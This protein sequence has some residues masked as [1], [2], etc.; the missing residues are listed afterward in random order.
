MVARTSP[1][2]TASPT[3]TFTLATVPSCGA[4]TGISIFMASSTRTVSPAFTAVPTPASILQIFPGTEAVT[5]TLP[6]A[7]AGAAAFGAA[8]GAAFGAGA[9]FAALTTGAAPAVVPS[10][11]V[12]FYTFPFTVMV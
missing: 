10:S 12:T 8:A 6:A 3:A 1:D 2:S 11:T 7:P 9:A 4:T 5:S